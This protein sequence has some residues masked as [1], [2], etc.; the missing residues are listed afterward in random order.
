LISHFRITSQARIELRAFDWLGISA[1]LTDKVSGCGFQSQQ[2]IIGRLPTIEVETNI[3]I[4]Y[5]EQGEIMGIEIIDAS[6]L[7]KA[8]PLQEIVIQVQ[9]E[10]KA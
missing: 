7:M 5:G 9:E 4:N 10:A 6:T 3:L 8:N 1:T 2:L